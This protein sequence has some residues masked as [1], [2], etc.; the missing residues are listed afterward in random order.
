[1]NIRSYSV[2]EREGLE[3]VHPDLGDAVEVVV[4][5]RL[6]S[7]GALQSDCRHCAFWKWWAWREMQVTAH[8]CRR[9]VGSV[10]GV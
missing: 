7:R 5:G 2:Q 4:D 9:R 10:P 1:M 3:L 8:C 6:L